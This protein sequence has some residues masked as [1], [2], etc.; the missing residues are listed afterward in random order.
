MLAAVNL[1]GI[2][3]ETLWQKSESEETIN[4]S[5]KLCD[6][7]YGR[8]LKETNKYNQHL[9]IIFNVK[10]AFFSSVSPTFFQQKKLSLKLNLKMLQKFNWF[11]I[12]FLGLS[13]SAKTLTSCSTWSRLKTA[14]TSATP[15]SPATRA[16][17]TPIP[18]SVRRPSVPL[19]PHP[20]RRSEAHPTSSSSSLDSPEVDP[21]PD[22]PVVPLRVVSSEAWGT[23]SPSSSRQQ[24]Q[25]Y[26]FSSKTR[27]FFL[28]IIFF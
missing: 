14:R 15:W 7:I 8:T 26:L 27:R 22:Q 13:L 21:R 11:T 9:C 10:E 23:D 4:G 1:Y 17:P 5:P 18:S 12:L 2:K 6:V 20:G 28:I 3:T 16:S 24:Q 19:H 25:Q